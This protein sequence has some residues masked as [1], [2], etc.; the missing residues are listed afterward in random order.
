MNTKRAVI[1]KSTAGR[2]YQG[3]SLRAKGPWQVAEKASNLNSELR[4]AN[5]ELRDLSF[6]LEFEV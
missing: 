1:R 4:T 6:F 5:F 3:K 2:L